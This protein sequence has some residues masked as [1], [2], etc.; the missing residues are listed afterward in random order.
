[1]NTNIISSN[2]IDVI[3]LLIATVLSALV[4]FERQLRKEPAGLRTHMLVCVGAT[5]LTIVSINFQQDPAR[6]IAGIVTGIGFIGAGTIIARRFKVV[7]LTTAASL[8]FVAALGIA[9]GTGFY[10][11]SVMATILVLIILNLW[12][13]ERK[14]GLK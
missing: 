10:W 9:V 6:I 5:L 14:L 4:G 12:K 8:W 13:V 1:M 2:L 3:K 7:G 11:L